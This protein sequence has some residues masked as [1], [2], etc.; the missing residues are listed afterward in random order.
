MMEDYPEKVHFKLKKRARKGIPDSYRGAAWKALTC[1]RQLREE[2]PSI[3]YYSL[4]K[5][6]AS[7]K[8][9][10]Y[11]FKDISRTFPKHEYFEDAYGKGQ[12]TLFNV[13]KN[14][15]LVNKDTGYVQGMGY[16]TAI[17]LM[18]MDEEDAFWTMISIL[19]K[20]GLKKYYLPSMPGL[21][22]AF[23]VLQQLIKDK[24][25]KVHEFLKKNKMSPS[26]YATQWFMTIFTVGFNFDCTVRAFDAFFAEG[27][28]IIYRIALYILKQ[29]ETKL[30][31]DKVEISDF[32]AIMSDYNKNLNP[33]DLIQGASK[34]DIT[35]K[36]IVM[37]EKEYEE[38]PDEE[39]L[40]LACV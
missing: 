15:A 23:Y 10:D 7:K 20:F 12:K 5:I 22:E 9:V 34:I 32:F 8:D 37:Y 27:P 38:G 2:N 6:K 39:I 17:L 35:R 4:L 3:N 40:K 31:Q 33:D 13:L 1:C 16:I 26:M 18:Y 19:S 21:L 29:N 11:I 14:L 30:T 28:K 24:L 25:P 36:Q